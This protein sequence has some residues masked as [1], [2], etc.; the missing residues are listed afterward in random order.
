MLASPIEE[1]MSF[2][3]PDQAKLARRSFNGP[4][5]I[6]GAAGTGKTVVGLHRA[7]YLARTR[8]GKV[9]VTTF[10]RTLP[11]VLQHLLERL[12]PDVA[13]RI[14]FVGVHAFARRLL[15]ARGVEVNL[16][17]QGA[18][19]SFDTVWGQ[20][21]STSPLRSSSAQPGYWREE[22]NYVLK[23][24]GSPSGRSTPTSS[25]ED[26]DVRL[27]SSSDAPCGNSTPPTTLSCAGTGFT[28]TRM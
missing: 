12:A 25:V 11:D 26:V 5:R 13:G 14:E 10:V 27:A 20:V 6:R 17:P 7:A 15:R 28:T 22:I 1:W 23:A 4:A 16:D 2:L 24:A 21:P 9:L 3:H 8:R 19:S 18:E